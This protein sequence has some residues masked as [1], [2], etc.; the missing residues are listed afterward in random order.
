MVGDYYFDCPEIDWDAFAKRFQRN[1][2][3]TISRFPYLHQVEAI[4]VSFCGSKSLTTDAPKGKQPNTHECFPHLRS[5][6]G[7]V[8]LNYKVLSLATGGILAPVARTFALTI[9]PSRCLDAIAS[10]GNHAS[11]SWGKPR[12]PHWLP[13]TALHRFRYGACIINFYLESDVYKPTTK[14]LQVVPLGCSESCSVL[15]RTAQ[16]KLTITQ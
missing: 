6:G 9:P 11:C 2:A 3:F 16:A 4:Y 12:R 15:C 1:I 14:D 8:R 10:G 13:K 5:R 7:G